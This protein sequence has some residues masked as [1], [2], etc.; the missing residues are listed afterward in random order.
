MPTSCN[1]SCSRSYDNVYVPV[2]GFT[3]PGMLYY[4][5]NVPGFDAYNPARARK[6]WQS[7][8]SPS[9]TLDMTSNSL[10]W[11]QESSALAQQW[12][13]RQSIH[14]WVVVDSLQNLLQKL[15]A[16]NWVACTANWG[17]FDPGVAL[18][19]YFSSTGNFSGTHDAV[20]DGLLNQGV[21][22]VSPAT[23]D[24]GLS[25]DQRQASRLSGRR[26]L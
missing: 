9:F 2:E 17:N 16:N 15:S 20:L 24:K 4:Q 1:S 25:E 19:I 10:F 14:A 8:G 6:L 3:A 5:K 23:R 13:A 7:V 26:G 11:V 12:S 21:Q 22:F 18:P